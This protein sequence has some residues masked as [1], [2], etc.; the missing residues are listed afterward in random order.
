MIN[1][2]RNELIKISKKKSIYITLLIT[3]AFVILTN[4]I[5]K[6]EPDYDYSTSSEVN[7]YEEQIKELD[8]NKLEDAP[9]YSSYKTEIDTI[10]LI[11]KYGEKGDSWQ[12]EVVYNQARELIGNM[13]NYK[14]VEKNEQAY[15]TAKEKYDDLV[16]KLDTGDWK[17][18]AKE[19]L[20]QVEENITTQKK[21]KDDMQNKANVTEIERQIASLELQKQIL[22]WRL[23]KDICYGDDYF[24]QCLSNYE[25]SRTEIMQY[26]SLE[27]NSKEKENYE[28]KKEYYDNLEKAAISKYDI[29]NGTTT[30][31]TGDARAILLNI[32]SE[33]E[34]F[35]II[36]SVMIAG[37]IVSEEFSKGTIKLLLVKPYKRTT[38]LAAKFI[39]AVIMLLI[40]IIIVMLMQ[41]V[42][43]G[44]AYGFDSFGTP[45][46]A[47]NHNT[48]T[49]E[50]IG[51]IKYLAMETVGKLPMYI[52]L[53]T[54]AFAFSTIFTNSALAIT[55]AL[56][57][58]MG[59]PMINMLAQQFKLEWIKFFVTP[60]WDLTQ[61]FF[62]KLPTF[63]GL[64]LG[65]SI[66]IIVIYML[67]MLITSFV[68]FKKKNIKNI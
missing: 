19:D 44:I 56:L 61:Y 15:N 6:I 5:Y 36:M 49:L 11:Q 4:V 64:T 34:I 47:Y 24:N 58:S 67:I 51:I 8:P 43:G 16:K 20:K 12:A 25:T 53:M 9:I 1:L 40:V 38:I 63:K 39:T 46:V 32:F 10:K 17:Y 37:T 18:F 14:Y 31:K 66:A 30:G 45:V 13:N 41:F 68:V 29:E 26:E 22:E 42:V 59:A 48:N 2:I 54:L 35:I 3:L 52:L 28:N 50:E 33:F 65:F 23:E 55:I 7:F 62:G 27:D 21:L 60:N 57:G